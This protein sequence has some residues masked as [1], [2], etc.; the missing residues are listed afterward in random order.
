M[1]ESLFI[2]K[3]IHKEFT[4]DHPVIYLYVC[5]N[6][7]SQELAISKAM[8]LLTIIFCPCILE[9]QIK[10]LLVLFLETKKEQYKKNL[11]K[12]KSIY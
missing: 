5:G 3:F 11:I 6:S 1:T 2:S 7:R 12:V 10:R 9:S 4:D 8:G